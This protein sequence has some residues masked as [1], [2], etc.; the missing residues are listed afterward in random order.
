[1]GW[2][3][4]GKK[5]IRGKERGTHFSGSAELFEW[6]GQKPASKAQAHYAA[7]VTIKIEN[8]VDIGGSP[9]AQQWSGGSGFIADAVKQAFSKQLRGARSGTAKALYIDWGTPIGKPADYKWDSGEGALT[10]RVKGR[11]S[12]LV[13]IAEELARLA[14]ELG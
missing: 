12:S 4:L 3:S 11:A 2:K 7:K 9:E 13:D 10:F 14:T 8:P 1:M 6:D 5:S